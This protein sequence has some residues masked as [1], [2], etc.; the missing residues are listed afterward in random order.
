MTKPLSTKNNV[1]PNAD[2]AAK[3]VDHRGSPTVVMAVKLW[4][5][6]TQSAAIKRRPVSAGNCAGLVGSIPT[7]T[8]HPLGRGHYLAAPASRQARNRRAAQTTVQPASGPMAASADIFPRESSG[9][10]VLLTLTCLWFR[11]SECRAV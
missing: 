11:R 4:E 6:T 8:D 1:M 9:E 10:R 3:Y 2:N 7:P 5:T